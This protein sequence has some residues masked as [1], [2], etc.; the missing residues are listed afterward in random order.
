[1]SQTVHIRFHPVNQDLRCST[2]AV[3][4]MRKLCEYLLAQRVRCACLN[5][6]CLHASIFCCTSS[7]PGSV[8]RGDEC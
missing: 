1:M 6:G 5:K 4:C 8:V 2:L 3:A 7:S